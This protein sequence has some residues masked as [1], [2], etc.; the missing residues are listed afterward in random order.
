MAGISDVGLLTNSAKNQMAF[1]ERMS[2]TAHV[3]EVADLKA[4][5]LNPVL[6]AGGN[7]ASTP[8]GAEGDFS[9]PNTGALA[10][11]V[12]AMAS[13][14]YQNGK[15][16]ETLTEQ[17]Q[18]LLGALMSDFGKLGISGLTDYL[19]NPTGNFAGLLPNA[20]DVL[21][22]TYVGLDQ[23]NNI[24]LYDSNNRKAMQY[25]TEIM[26][27]LDLLNLVD[28]G[29]T[30]W[31]G[32][33]NSG[34][35][36]AASVNDSAKKSSGNGKSAFYN[37]HVDMSTAIRNQILSKVKNYFSKYEATVRNVIN[38]SKAGFNGMNHLAYVGRTA[39]KFGMPTQSTTRY[40]TR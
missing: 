30:A 31:K 11:V 2:N 38:S 22:N 19:K 17:S 4:A 40:Y 9:D 8:S 12:N 39:A 16:I 14:S 21:K 15:A 5:G 27:A 1:Q 20:S 32:S 25:N 10:E 23:Y 24:R 35:D 3:R 6:S 29:V 37:G 13:S 34:S 28:Y 7:G 18:T 33:K 26:S 36:V